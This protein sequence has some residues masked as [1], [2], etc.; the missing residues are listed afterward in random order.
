MGWGGEEDEKDEKDEKEEECVTKVVGKRRKRE[1]I[2]KRRYGCRIDDTYPG[3]TSVFSWI[4]KAVV[5][6]LLRRRYV[7]GND[8][9]HLRSEQ[10]M[11]S[12]NKK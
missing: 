2:K 5:S 4:P 11:S 3:K 7:L 1:L 9:G 10:S 8:G 12:K 6:R